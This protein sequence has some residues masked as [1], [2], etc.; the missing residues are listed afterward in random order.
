MNP[1][2][3]SFWRRP[4]ESASNQ[5]Q[6]SGCVSSVESHAESDEKSRSRK[7]KRGKRKNRQKRC[8]SDSLSVKK[9]ERTMRSADH[10]VVSEARTYHDLSEQTEAYG[11]KAR[12]LI[13]DRPPGLNACETVSLVR[14]PV[15]QP[16]NRARVTRS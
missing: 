4:V 14:R 6:G 9:G 2:K 8:S 15:Q 7:R 12:G 13:P 3:S 10:E 11:A 1:G 16:G 5:G